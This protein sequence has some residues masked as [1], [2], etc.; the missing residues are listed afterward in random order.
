MFHKNRAWCVSEVE[1]SDTLASMLSQQ[2]WVLCAGFFITSHPEYLF[3]N[4]ATSEDG[5]GEYG[6][7]KGGFDALQHNQIESIT[8][9]WCSVL[10]AQKYIEEI[11]SGA[12]DEHV[13]HPN[14]ALT[15]QTPD[16]HGTCRFCA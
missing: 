15:L 16:I 6:I 10:K 1:D 11:L 12:Y 8:F 2:T 13:F 9:S 5:A 14:I 4:D 7:I 3:L